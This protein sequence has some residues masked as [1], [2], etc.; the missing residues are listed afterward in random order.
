M[1]AACARFWLVL[2]E[3]YLKDVMENVEHERG[4]NELASELSI[5]ER[6]VFLQNISEG[7]RCCVVSDRA[8]SSSDGF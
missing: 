4:L 8:L 5:Q 7:Q 3:C 2:A 1:E 6:V